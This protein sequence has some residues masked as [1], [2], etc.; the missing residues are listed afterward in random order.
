MNATDNNGL[1][2]LIY[3]IEAKKAEAVLYLITL[4]ADTCVSDNKNRTAMDYANAMGFTQIVE[5]ISKDSVKNVD[6]YGN[7]PLHQSCYNGQSEVVKMMVREEGV[8]VNARNDEGQ[9]PL[10]IAVALNNLA[11]V[12]I[13]LMAGAEPNKTYKDGTSPLQAAV[14][15][16]NEHMVEILINHGADINHSNNRGETALMLAAKNGRNTIVSELLSKNADVS[17]ADN[18][19]HTAL[20]YAAEAG[21]NEI[22]ELLLMAGAEG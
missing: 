9:T 15:K 6:S 16:G 13:L 20:H 14:I 11:I 8:D 22:T 17:Q 4:G 12:E 1:T 21:Y 5:S 19:A 18:M 10:F 2:P 3:G 7:T